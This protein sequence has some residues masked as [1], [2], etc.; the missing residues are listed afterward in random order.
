MISNIILFV[1]SEVLRDTYKDFC[2]QYV[3]SP[4]FTTA[5]DKRMEE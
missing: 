3:V 1:I 4:C 2:M 5:G